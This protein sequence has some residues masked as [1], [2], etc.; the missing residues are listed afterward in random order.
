MRRQGE[1]GGKIGVAV[2]DASEPMMDA[3]LHGC[4]TQG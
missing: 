2:A 1:G 3:G 4:G